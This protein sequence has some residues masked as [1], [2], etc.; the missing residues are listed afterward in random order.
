MNRARAI[1]VILVL[2]GSAL[3]NPTPKPKPVSRYMRDAGILYLETVE[4][5]NFGCDCMDTWESETKSLEDR[6]DVALKDKAQHRSPG[7]APYWDLLKS[8][9]YA[10]RF[11]VTS[12]PPQRKA[13]SHAYITCQAH[14]HTIAIEGDY[15]DGD[16]G[17]G[18]AIDAATHQ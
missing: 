1:A 7:D 11:Y 9:K 15:F 18:D 3:A 4:K 8:V 5:L 10:R 13:W 6:I 12:D 17:C 14:A 2:T 16:G